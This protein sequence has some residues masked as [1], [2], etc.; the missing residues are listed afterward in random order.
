LTREWV[1]DASVGIKLFVPEDLS[2]EAELV[3]AQLEEVPPA[4]LYVPDLFYLEC[5][6]I[7][8]KYVRRFGYPAE[9]AQESL[10][11]LSILALQVIGSAQFLS[12]ALD[13]ALAQ[14]ITAYDACYAALA[15]WLGISL[16]SA[17]EKLIRK[18]DGSGV[19]ARWLGDL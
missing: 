18:L 19:S 7:L 13:L 8:W 4:R 14:E 6:N 5:T 15:R 3:F 17:D 1:V 10:A 12:S 9:K 11:K 16:L 2:A